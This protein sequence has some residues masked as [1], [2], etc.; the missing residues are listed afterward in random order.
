M[1]ETDN[2]LVNKQYITFNLGKEKYGIELNEGKEILLPPKI[3]RVPN[4]PFYVEGV[5]NIR[6]RV[7]PVLDIKSILDVKNDI[8]YKDEDKRIIIIIIEDITAGFIVDKMQGIL[9]F[10]AQYIEENT[11]E[12]NSDFIKLLSNF[13]NCSGVIFSSLSNFFNC[14]LDIVPVFTLVFI[15]P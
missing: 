6:G 4:T 1:S 13:A 9:K 12:I 3:I 7:I 10:K 15:Q 2:N 14:S 5:I 8:V 11:N